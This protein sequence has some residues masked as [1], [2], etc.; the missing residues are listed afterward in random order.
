MLL[1]GQFEETTE[2]PLMCETDQYTIPFF[3]GGGG[4]NVVF[5]STTLKIL[6]FLDLGDCYFT[7]KKLLPLKC[8]R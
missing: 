3:F 5:C 8:Q 7:L 1:F 6:E 2:E 4:D